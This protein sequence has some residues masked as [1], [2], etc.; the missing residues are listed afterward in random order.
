MSESKKQALNLNEL[1]GIGDC[2]GYLKS[3]AAKAMRELDSVS[4]TIKLAQAVLS[5][6]NNAV[7]QARRLQQECLVGGAM[8]AEFKRIEEM[9]KR[10][11]PLQEIRSLL[12]PNAGI[13]SALEAIKQ[14]ENLTRLSTK[15]Q[16][17]DAFSRCVDRDR[18]FVRQHAAAFRLPQVVETA[19]LL[20]ESRASTGSVAAFAQQHM[21]NIAA[22]QDV[23]ASMSSPWLRNL[24]AARSASALVEL[25]SLGAA[26]RF[27]RG[28]DDGLAVALRSDFGDWRDRI[29]FPQVVFEDPVARA[30]F[31]A[32]RGFNTSLTDFP[33]M[34]FQESLE[35][36]GLAPDLGNESE[37]FDDIEAVDDA[38]E[39]A[40]R[41]TNKCHNYLQRMER[42]LRQFIDRAM[43]AQYGPEWPRKRLPPKMLESWEH[44]KSRAE[45]EGITLTMFIDVADF[46]DYEAIICKRDHWREVFEQRFRRTESVRESFQRLYPIRL[47]T[48][49]ARFVTKEDELYVLA[50][51][52]RLLNAIRT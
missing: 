38:E 17:I 43:T 50:E 18:E 46:T 36:A 25:H 9:N 35:R 2:D 20:A 31:Y 27:S 14:Q 33:D 7:A 29:S 28:F 15:L 6:E 52:M 16:A 4:K 48:M 12:G 30:D 1:Y 21:S 13:Q 49:H 8:A 34:A 40:F 51:T 47:A 24:E 22:Q 32:E 26:L 10:F 19:R 23:I 42:R 37:C 41:R 44:K 45:S 11:A 5:T 39:A 3:H